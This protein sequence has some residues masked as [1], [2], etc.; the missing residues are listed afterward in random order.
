MY[1]FLYFLE[2]LSILAMKNAKALEANENP[3]INRKM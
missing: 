1:S 3:K 2:D